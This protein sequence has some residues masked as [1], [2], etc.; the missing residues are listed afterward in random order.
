MRTRVSIIHS[1]RPLRRWLDTDQKT[2]VLWLRTYV[3]VLVLTYSPEYFLPQPRKL[4]VFG[5][6]P[7][8]LAVTLAPQDTA[9]IPQL[10]GKR[11]HR[12]ATPRLYKIG[13]GRERGRREETSRRRSTSL[14]LQENA[15]LGTPTTSGGASSPAIS[16]GSTAEPHSVRTS[17]ARPVGRRMAAC[18][19]DN[20]RVLSLFI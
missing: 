13:G 1:K 2:T 14:Q 15:P 10:V 20:N 8:P 12:R 4:P 16:G 7:S 11:M 9:P 18:D 3:L 6:A 5:S 17:G 19:T